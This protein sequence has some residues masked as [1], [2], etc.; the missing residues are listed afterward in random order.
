VTAID[1]RGPK[2]PIFRRER[3]EEFSAPGRFDHVVAILSLHHV[4][5]LGVALGNMTDL[6]RAA[7]SLVVVEFGW[8]RID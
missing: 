1:P 3:I 4:E 5:D 6:L 8:D 7:G 2:G